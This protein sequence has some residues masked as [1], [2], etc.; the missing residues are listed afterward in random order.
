MIECGPC[1]VGY[2]FECWH[3][4]EEGNCHC[5]TDAPATHISMEDFQDEPKE[6]GGQVKKAASVKDLE[7]TGRKRA[8]ILYPIPA[9]GDPG[10]PMA[11]EWSGLKSAGGGIVPI[12]GC[13][14]GL[15]KNIHHG[16]DK[17]TLSNFVKNV[18]RI[19]AT[20]HNRWHTLNDPYYSGTRPQGDIPYLPLE[21]HGECK[22]HDPF[23][24]ATEQDVLENEAFWAIRKHKVMFD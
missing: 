14:D 12:V 8:A 20:C 9:E 7:S 5:V 21:E 18:H 4:D 13:N 19:C 2:H 15:A 3:P 22:E 16:P 10:F 6:R 24:K 11:C 17:N 23:T 1:A